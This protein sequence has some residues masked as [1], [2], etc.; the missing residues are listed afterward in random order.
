MD[1]LVTLPL[2]LK[3]AILGTVEG[4]TEFLPISSTGHLILTA[5]L[6]GFTGEKAKLFEVAIQTGAMLS[7][8]WYYRARIGRVLAGL[9][10]RD[11]VGEQARRFAINLVIGF[12]P[13]A[14]L[15]VIFGSAIKRVLFK[16]VPVALAFVLGAF[17][18][19]WVERRG[20]A[21]TR[22]P[23][24]TDVD[25]LAPLDALKLGL[26]QA[27][28]LVPGT[29]RSGAT[30]MG[31]MLFGLSRKA[32]TEFSFFLAIPTLVGAGVYDTYKYRALL[33][34]ADAPL[35]GVGLLTA[36]LSA[37]VCVHW[38]IWFVAT[39]DFVPFAWYRIAFG[40]VVL[41]TAALGILDW[42]A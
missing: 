37:L 25:Q 33:S 5:S 3:A 16:P 29:S 26:A 40:V 2:L 42:A 30:I 17:V 24:I 11:A 12:L 20:T 34:L 8:I 36:F 28:A 1:F 31:G 41:L 10:R 15:G 23:R 4:L 14:V 19:L 21:A 38:L 32:A 22:S 39:H 35:F 7:V 18:I 27:F 9:P 13:A 6:L